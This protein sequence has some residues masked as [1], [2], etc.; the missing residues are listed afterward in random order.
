MK[1]TLIAGFVLASSLALSA[2]AQDWYHDRDNR[3]HDDSWRAQVFLQVRSDLEHIWSAGHA[4]DKERARLDRTKRELTDLQANLD[5]GHF[6]NGHLNDVIDSLRK[7][8]NDERLAPRDR[9]VLADD[10]NR[11]H[12]YQINHE[13]WKH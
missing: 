8:S 4:S 5:R 2:S 11:L 6:D 10:V 9:E 13:H 7:S 3:Y 12:D 1:K